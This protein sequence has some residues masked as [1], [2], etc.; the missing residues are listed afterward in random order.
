MEQTTKE[1]VIERN[2]GYNISSHLKH[3]TKLTSLITMIW[4]TQQRLQ[5][6]LLTSSLKTLDFKRSWADC[7]EEAPRSWKPCFT[8]CIVYGMNSKTEPVSATVPTTPLQFSAYLYRPSTSDHS[9]LY[10]L[11]E[12]PCLDIFDSATILIENMRSLISNCFLNRG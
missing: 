9:L 8:A 4:I 6:G 11:Q 12:I 1:W 2:I 10:L 5:N 7:N 3:R